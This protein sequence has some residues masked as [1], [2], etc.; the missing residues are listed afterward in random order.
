MI[1]PGD[2]GEGEQR[3]AHVLEFTTNRALSKGCSAAKQDVQ[4]NSAAPNVAGCATARVCQKASFGI[5]RRSLL[6]YQ[7]VSFAYR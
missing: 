4:D 6:S 7:W 3:A 1:P 2:V 5:V